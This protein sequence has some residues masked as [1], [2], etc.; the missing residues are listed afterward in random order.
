MVAVLLVTSLLPARRWAYEL[1]LKSH[2]ALAIALLALLWLHSFNRSSP[3]FVAVVVATSL[4][5]SHT[6]IWLCHFIWRNFGH[7]SNH[8]SVEDL[9]GASRITISLNRSMRVEPG[10]Y[11]YLTLPRLATRT[12]GMFQAH[13]Y[14][15]I[16]TEAEDNGS[17]A[18]QVH[19]LVAKRAGFSRE[20]SRVNDLKVWIDGPYGKQDFGEFDKVIFFAC[21]VGITAYLF[22]IRRLLRQRQRRISRIQRILLVWFLTTS[23][24][25]QAR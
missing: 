12:Y 6:T 25:S 14:Y 8:L 20:I 19:C 16:A 2:Q 1:F 10:Q 15:I 22:S 3:G 5:L 18:R 24:V 21:G 11:V 23:G 7:G 4:W 13:P 9:G 17:R